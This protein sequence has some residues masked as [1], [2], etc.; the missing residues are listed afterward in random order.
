MRRCLRHGFFGSIESLCFFSQSQFSYTNSGYRLPYEHRDLPPRLAF[1]L[2][3]ASDFFQAELI[4]NRAVNRLMG[5]GEAAFS[6]GC[7][8]QMAAQFQYVH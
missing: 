7:V 8:I 3:K 1:G 4:A 5:I 2:L 6:D